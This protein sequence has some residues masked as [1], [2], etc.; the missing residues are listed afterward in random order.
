M[1]VVVFHLQQIQA[2]HP[3]DCPV[4]VCVCVKKIIIHYKSLHI[5]DIHVYLPNGIINECYSE[6]ICI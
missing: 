2:V 3:G 5:H 6:D 4:F 1:I